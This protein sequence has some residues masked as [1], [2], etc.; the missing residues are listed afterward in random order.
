LNPLPSRWVPCPKVC[1]S[2]Y[3][4]ACTPLGNPG[5][6]YNLLFGQNNRLYDEHIRT[7]FISFIVSYI[8]SLVN[9]PLHALL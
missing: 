2:P 7:I 9:L 3:R 6:P 4:E 1:T 5:L 8:L